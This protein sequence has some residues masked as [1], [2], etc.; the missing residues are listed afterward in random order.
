MTRPLVARADSGRITEALQR[1]QTA[2]VAQFI[3]DNPN[4]DLAAFGLQPADLD[5]WLGHG[6][7]FV[8]ALHIGNSPT[9]DSSLVY[10]QRRGL[11][12]RRDHRQ[13]TFV[14]VVRHGE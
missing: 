1:L 11:E 9:N 3:T 13:G 6:T 8:T 12:H 7:N 4:A 5:L 14:T 10:A 2:R